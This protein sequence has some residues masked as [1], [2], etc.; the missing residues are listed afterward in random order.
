MKAAT[1]LL[2]FLLCSAIVKGQYTA[3]SISGFAY[4]STVTYA[5]P[6][7]GSVDARFVGLLNGRLTDSSTGPIVSYYFLDAFIPSGFSIPRNDYLDDI[8]SDGIEPHACWII[9]NFYPGKN[10]T[11]Q[12]IDLNKETAAIQFAIWHYTFGL[13]ISSISDPVIRNRVSEI[14]TLASSN[15]SSVRLS[16]EFVMDEDPEFF[17][18]KTVDDSGEPIAID[19]IELSFT[20]GILSTY[21]ISTTLPLGISERVQVIGANTGIIDAFSRKFVFP[22]GSIFRHDSRDYPRIFLAKPGFGARSF[23]YDWGTL[24]VELVSFR[25]IVLGNSVELKWATSEEINNSHFEVERRM[26]SGTWINIGR[27]RGGGTVNSLTEYEYKDKYVA[28][29]TYQYRLKQVDY[30]GNYEYFELAQSVS[31][32]I[33]DRLELGQ[34]YPN[35]FNPS[36]KINYKLQASGFITLKVFDITGKQVAE[37]VKSRKDAGTYEVSFD[38]G[39]FGITAGVYL[40]RLEAGDFSM[41]KKMVVLE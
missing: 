6:V 40:Y 16:V 1:L 32:G 30:N 34:N 37:L 27:V 20:E 2:Y 23:V 36:T 14:R 35:P 28:A 4:G 38:A 26:S 22:K 3:A 33:P 12:L 8:T 5:D 9:N 29:G 15:G 24:P 31:V 11:G 41:T 18:I 19:S 17:S 7:T 25:S 39:Q 10:G 13:Q 21:L